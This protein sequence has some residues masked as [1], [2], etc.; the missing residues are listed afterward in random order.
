MYVKVFGLMQEDMFGVTNI[1]WH[2]KYSAPYNRP[3]MKKQPSKPT[4]DITIP[5]RCRDC[6]NAS[7]FIEN[8][9]YCKAMGRRTCAC[10]RYGRVCEHFQKK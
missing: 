5:V 10:R 9:C 8:S 3:K 2:T 1:S 7:E 4:R 6:V